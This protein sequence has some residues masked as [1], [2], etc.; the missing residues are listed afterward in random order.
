MMNEL[1]NYTYSRRATTY[2]SSLGC[3]GPQNALYFPEVVESIALRICVGWSNRRLQ[4]R[5]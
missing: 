5:E 4:I 3:P 1:L 2:I